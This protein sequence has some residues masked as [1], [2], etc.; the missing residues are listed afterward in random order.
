MDSPALASR[1]HFVYL[2]CVHRCSGGA[3]AV[4]KVRHNVSCELENLRGCELIATVVVLIAVAIVV[5]VVTVAVIVVVA[6]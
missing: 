6:H 5:V 4:E 3:D 1:P 2:V